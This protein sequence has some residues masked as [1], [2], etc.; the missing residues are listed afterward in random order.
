[1]FSTKNTHTRE[2]VHLMPRVKTEWVQNWIQNS[3]LWSSNFTSITNTTYPPTK[4]II[5][6]QALAIDLTGFVVCAYHMFTLFTQFLNFKS[7]GPAWLYH[8]KIS[9][10][11]LVAIYLIYVLSMY[12]NFLLRQQKFLTYQYQYIYLYQ[13][14]NN[15]YTYHNTK[16][17]S[18]KCYTIQKY[19]FSLQNVNTEN[20]HK[21]YKKDNTIVP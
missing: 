1:M 11:L 12:K 17:T 2:F 5:N 14:Y 6:T 21:G 7:T 10:Y 3:A 16:R 13:I 9:L 15:T 4:I 8:V 18:Q 19:L 20:G